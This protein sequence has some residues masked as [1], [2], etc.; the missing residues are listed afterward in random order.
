[1]SNDNFYTSI[2]MERARKIAN[3]LRETLPE[4]TFTLGPGGEPIKSRTGMNRAGYDNNEMFEELIGKGND[5]LDGISVGQRARM[6]GR[7]NRQSGK[8]MLRRSGRGRNIV[9]KV[10]SSSMSQQSEPLKADPG[11]AK[12]LSGDP[13]SYGF[14]QDNPPTNEKLYG[15]DYFYREGDNNDIDTRFSNHLFGYDSLTN[16]SVLPRISND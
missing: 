15:M 16:D 6:M 7:R 9:G 11:G 14:K 1:M 13:Q 10:S 12:V 4:S 2:R 3:K 5:R 8:N